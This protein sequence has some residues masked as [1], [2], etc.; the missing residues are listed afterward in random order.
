MIK[1]HAEVRAKTTRAARDRS[2]PQAAARDKAA[3]FCFLI[4][5]RL[6]KIPA[7]GTMDADRMP[8][9]RCDLTGER[10]LAAPRQLMA[11]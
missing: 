7:D 9:L 6:N 4:G 8:M 1:A 10:W 2:L 5:M 3:R 11:M